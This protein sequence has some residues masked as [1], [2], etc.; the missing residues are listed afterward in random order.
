[1]VVM[2]DVINDLLGVTLVRWRKGVVAWL[3]D[4]RLR[5]QRRVL[6]N[7]AEK[8]TIEQSGKQDGKWKNT[9]SNNLG[10]FALDG[11]AESIE[12]CD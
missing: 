11:G 12:I 6:N 8:A 7:Y 9:H 4:K 5:V 10:D 1:M 3:E 2:L